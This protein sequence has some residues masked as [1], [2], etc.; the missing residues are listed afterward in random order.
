VPQKEKEITNP[1]WFYPTVGRRSIVAQLLSEGGAQ[2]I[3]QAKPIGKA[4]QL[5]KIVFATTPDS[6]N[7][8]SILSQTVEPFERPNNNPFSASET[9]VQRT[10]IPTS[11]LRHD[12]QGRGD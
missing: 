4:T 10:P 5:F 7:S 11:H 2:C 6:E 3:K 8:T 12:A 1:G 9:P